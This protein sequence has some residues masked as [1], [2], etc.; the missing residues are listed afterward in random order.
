MYVRSRPGGL[1]FSLL[2][3]VA[4]AVMLRYLPPM[5]ED[6]INHAHLAVAPIYR[7]HAA[8]VT[9]SFDV[10]DLHCDT[11]LWGARDLL[12]PA[13]H[14]FSDRVVGQ[15]DLP[16]LVA[17]RVRVQVFAVCSAVSYCRLTTYPVSLV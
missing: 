5:L 8:S 16:R 6:L 4:T 9:S 15:V 1:A 13:R 11:L 3:G 2:S 7:T 10:V 17:G 14:P 12:H